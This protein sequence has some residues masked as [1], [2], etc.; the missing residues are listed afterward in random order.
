MTPVAEHRHA[1]TISNMLHGARIVI[2]LLALC[3]TGKTGKN[4]SKSSRKRKAKLHQL[5]QKT[6]K[7]ISGAEPALLVVVGGWFGMLFVV[8]APQEKVQN[9][10]RIVIA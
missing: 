2:S 1:C 3:D 9:Q 7:E 6:R 8:W 10:K 5:R 4:I